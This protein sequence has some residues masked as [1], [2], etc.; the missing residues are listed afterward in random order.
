MGVKR[1]QHGAQFKAQVAMAAVFGGD[2]GGTVGGVRSASDDDWRLEA[3]IGEADWGVVRMRR[4]A[5]GRPAEWSCPYRVDRLALGLQ[6][7]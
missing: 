7:G 1:K 5:G 2:P 4:Q 6:A 3:G